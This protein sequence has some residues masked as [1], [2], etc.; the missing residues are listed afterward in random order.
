MELLA[1]GVELG[2]GTGGEG[3]GDGAGREEFA[4]EALGEAAGSSS[5]GFGEISASWPF[6][7]GSATG[8]AGDAACGAG[9]VF[10]SSRAA[11]RETRNLE[12][13]S[14]HDVF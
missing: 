9:L 1:D 2:D 8:F 12:M 11:A 3:C 10:I 6:V 14:R 5:I 4:G 13:G 7:L